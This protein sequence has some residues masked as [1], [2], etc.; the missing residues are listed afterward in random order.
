M[1]TNMN[2]EER[3]RLAKLNQACRTVDVCNGCGKTVNRS[4]KDLQ[5]MRP[6]RA[7]QARLRRMLV[8]RRLLPLLRIIGLTDFNEYLGQRQQCRRFCVALNLTQ[9]RFVCRD[10]GLVVVCLVF[11]SHL[12]SRT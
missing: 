11:H 1:A 3:H 9:I 5:R 12:V 6:L 4:V 2:K 7:L 10:N 8:L